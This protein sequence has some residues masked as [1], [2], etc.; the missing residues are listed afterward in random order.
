MRFVVTFFSFVDL[1]LAHKIKTYSD[2]YHSSRKRGKKSGCH[3]H[4]IY[5]FKRWIIEKLQE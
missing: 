2:M 3:I 1:N 5:F 4:F